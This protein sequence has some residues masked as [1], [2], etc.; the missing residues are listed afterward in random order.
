MQ[1]FFPMYGQSRIFTNRHS[2]LILSLHW[3]ISML[4]LK[5]RNLST[6]SSASPEHG[7]CTV[8]MPKD[9]KSHSDINQWTRQAK[10][11]DK[12]KH[13]R[14]DKMQRQREMLGRQHCEENGA[15]LF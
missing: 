6:R 8:T 5:R 4:L 3:E 9:F 14:F 12:N 10:D 15:N 11:W 13:D 2:A 1:V 7:K